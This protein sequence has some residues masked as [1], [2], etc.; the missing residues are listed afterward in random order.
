[1]SRPS[2][3]AALLLQGEERHVVPCLRGLR[4]AD[5]VVVLDGGSRN[6]APEL[7]RATGA[8]VHVRPFDNFGAQRKALF[9]LTN[10]DWVFFVDVDER[11][12]TA[13]AAE[14]RCAVQEGALVGYWVPRRNYIWG[15]WIKGGGWWPDEQLRLLRR[16]SATYPESQLVHEVAAVDGPTGHL[17]C[18]LVHYNYDTV[19]QFI[20]KQAKYAGLEAARRRLAGEPGRPRRLLSMPAR[21]LYY[22]LIAKDGLRDGAHGV[23]L[24]GLL[25]LFRF[26]V[27]R[28]LLRG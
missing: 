11:V 28:R 3:S 21:E 27:E 1:M 15:R 16:D 4:W 25:A 8:A 6:R 9:A 26:D 13:L 18:A 10:C 24:A 14:I 7:A 20:A 22:R 23:L 17:R 19:G 5:E 2:V 12:P